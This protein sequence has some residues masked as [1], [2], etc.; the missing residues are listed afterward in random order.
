M[1]LEPELIRCIIFKKEIEKTIK[2]ANP[3]LLDITVAS[4]Y[5]KSNKD[6]LA[7]QLERITFS[8]EG[9]VAEDQH[10]YIVQPL[11]KIDQK[12]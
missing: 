9:K 2:N 10:F 12:T 7:N 5:Y 6:G 4:V 1:F 8:T 3:N 11:K